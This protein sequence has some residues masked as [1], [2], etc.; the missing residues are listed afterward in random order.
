MEFDTLRVSL[1]W[2]G[3]PPKPVRDAWGRALRLQSPGPVHRAGWDV[4]SVGPDGIDDHGGGD[5]ILVGEDVAV[6]STR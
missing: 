6:V 5:D 3:R 2:M 4:W 1:Q